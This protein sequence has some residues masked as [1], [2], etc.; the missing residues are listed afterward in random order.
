ME[1]CHLVTTPGPKSS[2]ERPETSEEAELGLK[3]CSVLLSFGQGSQSP[4]K[5]R[6]LAKITQLA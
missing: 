6:Q 1:S 4:E 5:D 2:G 3:G